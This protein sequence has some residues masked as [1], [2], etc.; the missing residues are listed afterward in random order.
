MKKKI[1]TD[2]QIAAK[3][4]AVEAAKPGAAAD[5]TAGAKPK[6]ASDTIESEPVET[7]EPARGR[8]LSGFFK[9]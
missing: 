5:R 2:E 9:R 7:P 3:V 4:A 6:P 8:I 1:W